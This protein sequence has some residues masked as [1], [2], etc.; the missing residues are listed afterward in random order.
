MNIGR[1]SEKT[2]LPVRTIHYYEEIELVVPA[3]RD[4]GYRD[5]SDTDVHKLSFLHRARGLGF[6]VEDCRALLTLYED[7]NRASADVKNIAA[8]HLER[9][10]EKLA[11]LNSLQEVLTHLVDSCDG[12]ARPDCPILDGLAGKP[13][14]EKEIAK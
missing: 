12:D 10:E 7:R 6:S 8:A 9:I 3:R 14:H 4:N 13:S 1:A 5:Y 2:G 11:E